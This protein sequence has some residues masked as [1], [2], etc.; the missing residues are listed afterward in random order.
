MGAPRPRITL[1]DRR[2]TLAWLGLFALAFALRAVYV[3]SVAGHPSVRYPMV[4]SLAYHERALAILSG[5]WLGSG[6]FYQDPLYPY[7]LAAVYAVFGVGSL[8]VLLAQAF[9]DAGTVLLVFAI[10]GRVFDA[11]VAW[12]AGLLAAGYKLFF[13]YD[14]LLLKVPLSV[15]L[16]AALLWLLL[17]ARDRDAPGAWLA[18][19]AALGAATLTRGNFLLFAPVAAAW[20]AWVARGRPARRAGAAALLALG[21]AVAVAPATLHNVLVGGDFVLVTSQAGQNFFIGNYRGAV[22]IYRA[23]RF[24]RGHPFFEREDFHREAERRTQR[25]MKPSEVSR[26]WFGQTL[27]V[28]ADDPGRFLWLLG[29]KARIYFN[30]YEVPDN[31]SFAFFREKVSALLRLPLPTF[32]F[33]LPLGLAGMVFARRDRGALLL[34]AFFATWAVSVILFYNMSRYRIPCVPALIPLAAFGA[35]RTLEALRARELRVAAA[36][37]AA[38]GL[39]WVL[40]HQPVIPVEMA[41]YHYNLGTRL[42]DDARQQREAAASAARSGE[43]PRAAA[44]LATARQLER[45]AE[46]EFRAGLAERP[47]SWRLRRALDRL[48]A[49]KAAERKGSV[50]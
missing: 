22:G 27:E 44:S 35:V 47:G 37:L 21:A 29:R 9:L 7:F 26:Y 43:T 23:P 28:I 33:L 12:V 11:R 32:G 18:A 39:G 19:G 24:L 30:A 46:E 16:T 6:V 3:W 49:R 4:D 48:L 13:Y 17:R 45:A 5:D 25:E 2:R 1:P 41:V 50:D 14:A 40:V 42:L 36:T 34:T 31:Q 15:F 38:L 20:A 8:G 10:A